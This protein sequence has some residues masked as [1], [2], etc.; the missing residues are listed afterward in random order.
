MFEVCVFHRLKWC[1]GELIKYNRKV[2]FWKVPGT[3]GVI[4][5]KT[6]EEPIKV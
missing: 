4:P 5:V 1:F 2:S 3:F 6:G